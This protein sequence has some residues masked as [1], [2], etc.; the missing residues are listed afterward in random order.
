MVMRRTILATAILGLA[1]VPLAL[2]A[3]EKQAPPPPPKHESVA[4]A[5]RKARE[6]R[7]TPAKPAK[8]YTND[9]IGSGPGT[10]SVVG[11]VPAEPE[12][13]KAGEA[14]KSKAE[15]KP[16]AKP[17][18]KKDEAYWRKTFG[19]ARA[20]LRRDQQEL[21]IM[22]RELAVLELQYY[23]DPQKAMEQQFTRKDIDEKRAKIETKKQEVQQD[24]QDLSDLEDQLRQAGGD[25][26]WARE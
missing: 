23:P 14:D 3:Q 7:K 22:Q 15:A 12:A 10:I 6:Q 13:T 2:A 5:A 1:T 16:A 24:Q 26:G 11:T 20:K 19:E 9:N 18:V 25:P 17:E 4:E 21:E 8:V